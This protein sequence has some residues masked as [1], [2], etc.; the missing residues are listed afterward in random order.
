MI[1]QK[2]PQIL[3][4][5]SKASDGNMDFRFSDQNQVLEN[6][7]KFLSSLEIS[8][9][10]VITLRQQHGNQIIRVNK[11]YAGL[12]S[13]SDINALEADGLMTNETGLYLVVKAADCHQIAFYDPKNEVIGLIHA[14]WKGLDQEIIKNA[15]NKMTREFGSKPR[16]LLAQFGPSIGPCCYKNFPGLQQKDDPKWQAYIT[17]NQDDTFNV[18]LWEMAEDQLKEAELLKEN[19][20]NPKIC[21]YHSGKYFSHRRAVTEKTPD[22]EFLTVLGMRE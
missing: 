5:T 16:D 14:G 15:V 12:G 1:F 7:Q 18:N 17:K 22:F 8:L 10:S 9:D 6:R 21:T 20:D 19:I 4:D 13:Q 3:F 2:Y 11:T